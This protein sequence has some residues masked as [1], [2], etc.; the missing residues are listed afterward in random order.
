MKKIIVFLMTCFLITACEK[1]SSVAE[2]LKQREQDSQKFIVT[3][4]SGDGKELYKKEARYTSGSDGTI[5]VV[6]MDGKYDQVQG[7]CFS[8]QQ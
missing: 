6:R 7:I 4:Y 1:Q 5:Y 2:Q 3:C 8:E